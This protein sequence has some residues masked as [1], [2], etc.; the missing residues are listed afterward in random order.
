MAAVTLQIIL[1]GTMK[2]ILI[3]FKIHL[4]SVEVVVLPVGALLNGVT[5]ALRRL[6]QME[7]RLQ[8]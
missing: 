2:M 8:S 3:T 6:M 4:S 1:L 7:T 5:L